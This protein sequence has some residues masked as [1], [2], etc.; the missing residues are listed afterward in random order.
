MKIYKLEREQFLLI[1]KHEAWSFFSDPKNLE[2]ITPDNMKFE[3]LSD[4]PEKIY[5]GIMILYKIKPILNIPMDWA[6]VI[7][8]IKEPYMFI[9]EQISGPYKLWHHQ[10]IFEEVEKGILMTDIVHYGLP[11][12]FLGKLADKLFIKKQLDD[13]FNFRYKFLEKKFKNQ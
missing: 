5:P 7:N 6:T 8:H 11:F 13:I 1:N 2:T 9:D 10:H 12:G 3:I 4:L